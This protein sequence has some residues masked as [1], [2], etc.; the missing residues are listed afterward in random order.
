MITKG[1]VMKA[2]AQGQR[3]Q[4]LNP[5]SQGGREA[6]VS[7]LTGPEIWGPPPPDQVSEAESS[8]LKDHTAP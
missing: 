3:E 4:V 5:H 7:P 8:L 2:I 6:A 1:P